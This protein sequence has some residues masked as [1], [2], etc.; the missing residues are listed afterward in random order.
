MT[1]PRCHKAATPV[2]IS[3]QTAAGWSDPVHP[4]CEAEV[5]AN[6]RKAQAVARWLRTEDGRRAFESCMGPWRSGRRALNE[7]KWARGIEEWWAG[8]DERRAT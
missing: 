6:L 1:C 3:L 8:R 7:T 4:G 2:A 5:M